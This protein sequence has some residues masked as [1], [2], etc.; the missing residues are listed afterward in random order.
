MANEILND[1]L[2]DQIQVRHDKLN[3]L[4][5]NG[6]DPFEVVKFDKTHSSTHIFNNFDTLENQDVSIAGRIILKRLMGKAAFCHIMDGYDKIQ[7]YVSINDIGENSYEAFKKMDIGDIIGVN[8]F[9]FKTRTGEISVHAKKLQLLSKALLPLPDK[10]HGLKDLDLK[11]RERYVDLI[12]NPEVKKTFVARSTIIKA[13]REFLDNRGFVEVDTPTLHTIQGGAEARP[14]ITHHNT[15]DLD[16]FMR[17]APELYL[18]RLIVGGFEK[19]Y[20]LGKV[21]RNEGMDPRHNPEFTE[22]EIYEAYN[23]YIGMADLTEA[24]FKHVLDRL[25]IGPVVEYQG[26]FVDYSKWR[27]VTMIDIVKEVTGIDFNKEN[28]KDIENKL[29]D[30]HAEV[31]KNITWGTLLYCA[32][33][34][35]V[36]KTLM[37]PTFILDYPIEISPLTKKKKSDPRLTERFEFFI[38][39]WEVGNAYS[40][41][42]DPLDQ[43]ERFEAQVKERENG[44]DEAQMLD[45]D[46]V[47]SLKYGLPPTGGVG[48]GIDRIVM[49]LTNSPSIRDVILFP[50]MKPIK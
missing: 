5:L 46:F 3:E 18:K 26:N 16:M 41:L 7:L 44:N 30:M 48:Y 9:V 36:E 19:V 47:N 43:L 33:E 45:N 49:L 22:L 34:N 12:V 24:M 11:Y 10:F 14:F 38:N 37:Q 40:E 15:L 42:N 2:T 1:E 25:H 27:R 4:K 8:G 32:F 17:I 28:I 39:G 35:F 20:E 31:P 29:K 21:F 23:D 50:T 13:I 6:E